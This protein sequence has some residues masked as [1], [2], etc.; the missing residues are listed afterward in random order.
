[1]YAYSWGRQN[2]FAHAAAEHRAAREAVALFDQSCFAKF[3]VQGRDAKA[4]MQEICAADMAVAPGRVV[5]TQWLNSKGGIEADLTVTRLAEDRYMVVTGAAVATRDFAWLT[6]HLGDRAAIAIDV[7]SGWAMLGVMGPKSRDLLAALSGADLSNTAFPFLASREI[8][9]GYARVRAQRIT[10]VGE[11]GWELYM[12][13]EFA[14]HV[15]EEVTRAG[16]AFGL[17]PAGYHAM[18]SLRVEKGYRHWGHDITAC[19][20]PLEAGL[21]FAVGWD[22]DV[23]FIG[24]AALAAQRGRPPA[25]RLVQFRLRD[26]EP[27]MYHDEPIYR[28]GVRVGAITSAAYGHT[29]GASVG[30]GYV[31]HPDGVDAAWLAA[32]EFTIDVAGARIPAEAGL[33]PFHDPEGVRVKG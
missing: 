33:R 16:V 19:D 6:R 23:D 3:L 31:R 15:H 32:G 4:A 13:S 29:L 26:P 22:K 14:A 30:M 28:D 5:Y 9:I 12:S 2:W 24:R 1:V 27:M 25:R 20:T 17:K 8:E 21:G 11:L 18:D 7:T 10:Y